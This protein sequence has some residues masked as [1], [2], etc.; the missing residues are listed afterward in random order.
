MEYSTRQN[1]RICGETM[2]IDALSF[3]MNLDDDNIRVCD[4][5]KKL[6]KTIK[7]EEVK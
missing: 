6:G 1:C 5:C 2:E 7:K 3:L 4:K